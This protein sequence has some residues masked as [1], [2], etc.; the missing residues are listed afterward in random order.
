M[1]QV[2]VVDLDQAVSVLL[3]ADPRDWPDLSRQILRQAKWADKYRKRTGKRHPDWGNGT[4]HDV[5]IRYPRYRP[6]Y[7]T[8]DQYFQAMTHF[9]RTYVDARHQKY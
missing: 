6:S 8:P 4:V 9:L 7:P 3:A 1:R 2:S 5:C